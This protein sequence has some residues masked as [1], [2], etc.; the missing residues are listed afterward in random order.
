LVA[1]LVFAIYISRLIRD[2]EQDSR[3]LSGLTM[4][5]GVAAAGLALVSVA[6]QFAVVARANEG[7]DPE[8][9]RAMLDFS[10]IAF[11]LMWVPLAVFLAATAAAG[12][13]LALLP[14]WLA[15]SAAVLAVGLTIG[16]AAMPA[17]QAGFIAIVLSFLWFVAASVALVRRVGAERGTA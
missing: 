14:R 13:R 2:R 6:A 1:L 3:L 16:L 12:L 17:G 10:G 4:G 5:A 11:V 7:I 9:A 15:I 8:M